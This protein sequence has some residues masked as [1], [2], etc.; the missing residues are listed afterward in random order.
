VTSVLKL[1]WP[2][3][4]R[5]PASSADGLQ[6]GGTTGTRRNLCTRKNIQR[7]M[8][9]TDPLPSHPVRSYFQVHNAPD[10]DYNHRRRSFLWLQGGLI[11]MFGSRRHFLGMVGTGL[12]LGHSQLLEAQQA[13]APAMPP[14]RSPSRPFQVAPKWR[15]STGRTAARMY[16]TP[17]WRS[18]ARLDQS[19]SVRST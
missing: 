3:R 10:S 1:Y 17:W 2:R 16:T 18:M 8:K 4:T 14:P 15:S 11:L 5:S 9:A 12:L 13:Q 19:C 6:G 7:R